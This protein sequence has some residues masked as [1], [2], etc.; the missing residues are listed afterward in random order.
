M[1][2]IIGNVPDINIT[3]L[4]ASAIGEVPLYEPLIQSKTATA[5]GF[6]P[7][8]EEYDKL[9]ATQN[10]RIR[11][12]PYAIGDG[13]EH[14]LHICKAPGMTS[15]LEPD[16]EILSHFEGFSDWGSVVQT[17]RTKTKKLDD[18]P[19]IRDT[20]YLK[21]DIQGFEL[22]ALRYGRKV[23]ENTLAIQVEMNFIPFYKKQPL[24]AEIDQR[25]RKS[26][27]VLHE[28]ANIRSQPFLPISAS[29]KVNRGQFLWTDA[30]YIRPFVKLHS[31]AEDS[32]LRIATVAH[33]VYR[34][35][36]L[37]ALALRH[38]DNK[39]GT[40]LEKTYLDDFVNA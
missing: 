2:N 30:H 27:F 21:L 29:E 15:F 19:E 23:L 10:S 34:S 36:S 7:Q 18:I 1:K 31:L 6:E 39:C 4:G 17:Q 32:L 14:T 11:Y 40:T 13:K 35:Y 22:T 12:L 26:G 24:F 20:H 28:F 9:S 16:M 37:S 3:D 33:E 25:L 38:Y 8:K 5:T